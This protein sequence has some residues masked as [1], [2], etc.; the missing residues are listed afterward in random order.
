M[1]LADRSTK[2][3]GIKILSIVGHDPEAN[4]HEMIKKEE[5]KLRASVRRETKQ[6]RVREKTS[7]RGLSSAYLDDDYSDDENAISIAAIKNKY[8]KGVKANIYSSDD[9]EGSDLEHGRKLERAKRLKDSEEE[10]ED[11]DDES[12][13][14]ES[15]K[16]ATPE[17]TPVESKDDEDHHS[18]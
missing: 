6:R 18:E 17:P 12:P 10:D 3:Q 1:S 15:K 5:D 4:R 16:E 2:T 7:N 11:G 13:E 8:K 14:K 9:D